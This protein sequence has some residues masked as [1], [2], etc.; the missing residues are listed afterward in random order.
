[1]LQRVCLCERER[2]RERE[3]E[4]ISFTNDEKLAVWFGCK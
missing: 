4:S 2:Q 1:L 3:K